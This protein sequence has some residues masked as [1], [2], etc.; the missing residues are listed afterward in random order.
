[1]SN[2]ISHVH[3]GTTVAHNDVHVQI[4][5]IFIL[6]FFHKIFLLLRINCGNYVRIFLREGRKEYIM[7]SLVSPFVEIN[8]ARSDDRCRDF[9]KTCYKVVVRMSEDLFLCFLN[10]AAI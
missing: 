4:K 7:S 1:M 3:N 9:Q 8:G 2:L 10:G 5:R 6:C